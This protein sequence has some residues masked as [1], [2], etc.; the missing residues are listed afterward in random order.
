MRMKSASITPF[1]TTR[2]S[3]FVAIEEHSSPEEIDNNFKKN[4]FSDLKKKL[5]HV[6][7]NGEMCM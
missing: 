7:F 4:H 2:R 5:F 6:Y 1:R 3:L